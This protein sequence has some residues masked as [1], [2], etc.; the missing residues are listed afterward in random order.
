MGD[1]AD[2]LCRAADLRISLES[3]YCCLGQSITGVSLQC[4]VLRLRSS[5]I[6]NSNCWGLEEVVGSVSIWHWLV[7]IVMLASPILGIVRGV[8]NGS[9]INSLLSAF[10]PLYGLI[11][12]FAAK[13]AVSV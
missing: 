4:D 2:P 13:K 8:G 9:I 10:I 6:E 12:Y 11:Y 5:V 3:T 1:D 7:V